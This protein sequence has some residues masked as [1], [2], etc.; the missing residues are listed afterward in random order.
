MGRCCCAGRVVFVILTLSLVLSL[1]MKSWRTVC[2]RRRKTLNDENKTWMKRTSEKEKRVKKKKANR[3]LDRFVNLTDL[4]LEKFKTSSQWSRKSGWWA[5]VAVNKSV[6]IIK[7]GCLR[8]VTGG[9]SEKATAEASAP[10]K[11]PIVIKTLWKATKRP[12]RRAG[13][14]SAM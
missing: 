5:L 11:R 8:P 4:R 13:L 1:E 12:R 7:T 2:G 14:A 10:Q 6:V 3:R 9:L